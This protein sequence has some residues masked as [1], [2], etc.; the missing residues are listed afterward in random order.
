MVDE[1]RQRN[2]EVLEWSSDSDPKYNTSMRKLSLLGYKSDW[3]FGGNL[4]SCGGE[5][6][7]FPFYMQDM[8]HIA[9][10]LRN[11]F[12]KTIMKPDK[13][14]FGKLYYI[15]QS[16]LK[17]LVECF[18]KDKH[19][20]TRTILNP[21]DK[22]N[23]DSVL[24][25]TDRKVIDMLRGNVFDSQGTIKF[26]EITRYIIDSYLDMSLK[27]IE[28]VR[29]IW[30]AVF[31]IRIWRQFVIS[32]KLLKLKDN[33]LTSNCY[34]CIELNAHSLILC[35]IHLKKINMPHLFVPHLFG[36]QQCEN[37]FRQI[38][39]FTTTYSTVANCSVKEILGRIS[40]IQL[41]NEIM[42]NNSSNFNFPSSGTNNFFIP[43]IADLPTL[44]EI[45]DE[46][47][48]CKND[49]VQDALKLGLIEQRNAKKFDF[50]CKVNPYDEMSIAKK[51][52]IKKSNTK[53]IHQPKQIVQ[54][55]NIVYFTKFCR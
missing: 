54:L 18:S 4:V 44:H 29:K 31:I 47:Q 14:P 25:M 8:V 30:Y 17:F 34:I 28:R 2:I 23:F 32:K 15:R 24:K 49:A 36:S 3:F 13:L 19:C 7:N 37:F 27:P 39:S 55:K 5:N 21:I 16:H 46:I 38:R 35:L 6:L 42:Y 10:K 20:L 41:L 51:R 33:F 53:I 9:T 12:L 52:C 22:Q 1:L 40:K 11:F 50:S 43:A 26:L 48:K 45:H